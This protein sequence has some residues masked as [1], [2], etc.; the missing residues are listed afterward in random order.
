MLP[1]TPSPSEYAALVEHSP[2]LIWRSGEDACCDYFNDTWLRFTGR[3]L[4]EELGEGWTLGVHAEDRLRCVNVYRDHFR[5]VVPFELEYRLRRHDGAFRWILSRGVPLLEAA[6][7]RGFIVSGIDVHER[8]E[9]ALARETFLRMMA[10]ELRTPLQAVQMF[11][12]VMRR[13]AA[14]GEGCPPEMFDRLEAQFGRFSRL[15]GDLAETGDAGGSAMR[16]ARLD[17]ATLLRKLVAVRSG[18]LQDAP[19]R[20]RHRLVFRGPDHAEMEGD[21]HRLEQVFRN[22]LDNALKFSPRGGAIEVELESS[23]HAHRVTVRDEGV[24]IPAQELSMVSRRFFRASNAP[25]RNFPGIGLG[26]ATAREIVEKHEG[27]LSV[28]SEAG[29]GTEVTIVLPGVG[30]G[31]P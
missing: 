27:S 10:H 15:V 22:V 23:D 20:R 19:G 29:R 18:E 7:F 25:R 14:A 5:R 9:S 13:G 1:A 24:G 26:L 11:V 8:H 2:V 3:S 21:Q 12:E 4:Q 28:A 31:E 6:E 30:G 17:L 16:N